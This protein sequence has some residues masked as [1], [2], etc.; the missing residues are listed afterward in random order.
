[1]D[2]L[3][4]IGELLIWCGS[5][6]G[7][8]QHFDAEWNLRAKFLGTISGNEET[9]P[10][11]QMMWSEDSVETMKTVC[12]PAEGGD[13]LWDWIIGLWTEHEEFCRMTP[14]YGWQDWQRPIHYA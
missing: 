6:D 7:V 10:L 8:E 11:P 14:F 13:N 1:M 4:E 2:E 12:A 5:V 9:G 3:P